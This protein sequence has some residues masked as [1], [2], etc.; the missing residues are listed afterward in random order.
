[1]QQRLY[2][3]TSNINILLDIMKFLNRTDVEN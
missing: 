2:P 1:M 3:S